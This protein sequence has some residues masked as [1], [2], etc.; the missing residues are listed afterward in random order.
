MR[1]AVDVIAHQSLRGREGAHE[2]AQEE[3]VG[4]TGLGE[5]AV[6]ERRSAGEDDYRPMPGIFRF[7]QEHQVLFTDHKVRCQVSVAEGGCR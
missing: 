4:V 6:L 5:D 1:A 3:T 7:K 2:G